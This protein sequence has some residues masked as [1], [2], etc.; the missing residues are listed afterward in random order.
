MNR[1]MSVRAGFTAL[2]LCLASGCP[3]NADGTSSGAAG[4]G[5]AAAAADCN[6]VK[7]PFRPN[8]EATS[9]DGS[10][11]AM[12]VDALPSPPEKYENSW[13]LRFLTPDGLPATDAT[14]DSVQPFMPAHGHDG[15]KTPVIT[16]LDDPATYKVDVIN[17]WMEGAWRV[18]FNVSMGGKSIPIV[19][20]AC[21]QD[22]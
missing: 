14:L 8:L 19:Y 22:H 2:L 10:L 17:L 16:K 7:E 13:T 3:K 21:I 15:K 6:E 12:I 9:A 18:T 20:W 11:K 5:M 1:A 4:S